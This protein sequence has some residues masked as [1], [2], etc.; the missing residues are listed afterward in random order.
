MTIRKPFTP[1]GTKQEAQLGKH[2]QVFSS[3]DESNNKV[4]E[5]NIPSNMEPDSYVLDTPFQIL[6]SAFTVCGAHC[7]FH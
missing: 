2:M 1:P 6:G 5:P 4:Y 3:S 7:L